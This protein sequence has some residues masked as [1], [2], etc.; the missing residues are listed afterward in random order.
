MKLTFP[1]TRGAYPGED[2]IE[3]ADEIS[4]LAVF[5][6]LAIQT[7][8]GGSETACPGRSLPP[9]RHGRA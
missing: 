2:W 5:V 8:H 7:M 9:E 4:A 3:G 6:P 1:G